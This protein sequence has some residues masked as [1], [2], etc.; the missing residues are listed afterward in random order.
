M[1]G[2]EI[3][4][5]A[6]FDTTRIL[7]GDQVNFSVMIDQPADLKLTLPF[8]KDSLIKNIEILSGPAIDTSG[9]SGN[10][11]R[12]TEKYLVTSFDSG[13]YRIDPVFAEIVDSKGLKRYFSDYSYLEVSRVK[14]APADT[15]AKIYDIAAPYR[16]PLTLGEI[17]PWILLALLVSAI[18]WL[19]VKLIRKFKRV[20]KDEIVP[21]ITEPAHVIAFRE[22]EKLKNEKLWQTGETKKYYIRLTEIIRQYLENRFGVNSL[23]LTTSET[24]EALIKTGFKKDES[25]NKLR[26]VLTG[27]DLVKFAK[28]KPDPAEN[29]S[30][31]S[32]SYDFVSATKAAEVIEEKSDVKDNQGEKGI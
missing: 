32:N 18:I 21:A 4:L 27:A 31:F 26:S 25:F 3:S 11:I 7:V 6:V 5:K 19:I 23:E 12:I 13:Y 29:E 30:V 22:L 2:Q 15:S 16:A 8:F 20:K 9:I 14:I 1:N 28:Y 10:K 17:L 24:L